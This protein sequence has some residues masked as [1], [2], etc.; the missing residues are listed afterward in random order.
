MAPARRAGLGKAGVVQPAGGP[1]GEAEEETAESPG[2]GSAGHSLERTADRG[3]GC[4]RTLTHTASLGLQGAGRASRLAELFRAV[5][6]MRDARV[7]RRRVEDPAD[8]DGAVV[9]GEVVNLE[10]TARDQERAKQ[11]HRLPRTRSREC[12]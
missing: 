10:R 12:G 11:Y 5:E 6:V 7:D 1:R 2:A 9:I 8:L 4:G 3:Y